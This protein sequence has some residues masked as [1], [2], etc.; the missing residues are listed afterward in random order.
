MGTDR[1]VSVLGGGQFN[2][3]G[4]TI[5]SAEIKIVP[6]PTAIMLPLT[7]FNF[8]TILERDRLSYEDVGRPKP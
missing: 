2:T 8:V 3:L 7:H 1:S 5:G 6:E 4:T